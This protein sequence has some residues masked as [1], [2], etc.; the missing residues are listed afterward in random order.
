MKKLFI[1]LLLVPFC[2]SQYPQNREYKNLS[3]NECIN[4]AKEMTIDKITINLFGEPH[5]YLLT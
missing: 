2:A 1:V 5:V 4:I 3:L